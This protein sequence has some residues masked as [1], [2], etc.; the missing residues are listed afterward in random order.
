MTLADLGPYREA[1][2]NGAW[3]IAAAGALLSTWLGKRKWHPTSNTVER[4]GILVPAVAIILLF[5]LARQ[6][7]LLLVLVAI[8]GLVIGT[9]SGVNYSRRISEWRFYKVDRGLFGRPVKRYFIGGS[10]RTTTA[11]GLHT[12][13]QPDQDILEDLGYDPDQVWTPASRA[14][15][16]TTVSWWY[17]GLV[18]GGTVALGVGGM[19]AALQVAQS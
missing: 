12:A 6:M 1:V 7:W 13:G 2:A 18:S 5:A 9:L 11:Q 15:N 17:L 16:E 3:G 8:I 19:I 14:K 4:V 10:D